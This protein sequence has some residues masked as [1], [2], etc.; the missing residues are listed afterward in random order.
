[1]SLV[2]EGWRLLGCQQVVSIRRF[3]CVAPAAG[4]CV[5]CVI[6]LQPAA[7]LLVRSHSPGLLAVVGLPAPRCPPRRAERSPA[8]ASCCRARGRDG[9]S[10]PPPRGPVPSRVLRLCCS[11]GLDPAR[12]GRRESCGCCA[13]TPVTG[14]SQPCSAGNQSA[15]HL[16]AAGGRFV[17][18]AVCIRQRHGEGGARV[19][20]LQHVAA[21]RAVQVAAPPVCPGKLGLLSAQSH[22]S[23][24]EL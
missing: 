18:G 5:C 13:D 10:A 12:V 3:L 9:S 19:G 14:D 7:G 24:W 2:S 11:L 17:A 23:V 4:C 1:M 15:S 6:C 20:F 22:V 16:R 21:K 8:T